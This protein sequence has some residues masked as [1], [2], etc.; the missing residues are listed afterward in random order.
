MMKKEVK[1]QNNQE[2]NHKEKT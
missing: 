2:D 1:C